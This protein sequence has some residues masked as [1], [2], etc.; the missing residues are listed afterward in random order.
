MNK[1]W[2]NTQQKW[3]MESIATLYEERVEKSGGVPKGYEDDWARALKQLD[4]VQQ[5][6]MDDPTTRQAVMAWWELSGLPPCF[7][8]MQF[9][10]RP[11]TLHLVVYMRSS[12]REKWDND[13]A[14]FRF[15]GNQFAKRLNMAEYP[16]EAVALHVVKASDHYYVNG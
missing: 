16:T 8:A 5:Q 7:F 13:L 10:Y 2:S 12:A 6:V 14:F 15:V 1:V 9:L 11:P 3:A 4:T